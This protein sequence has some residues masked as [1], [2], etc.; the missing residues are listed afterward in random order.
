MPDS[1]GNLTVEE[2]AVRSD[3]LILDAAAAGGSVEDIANMAR[4]GSR[5]TRSISIC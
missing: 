2:L 4:R 1:K 3:S 5:C